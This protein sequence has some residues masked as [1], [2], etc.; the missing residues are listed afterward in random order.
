MKNSTQISRLKAVRT[1][2]ETNFKHKI[3]QAQISDIACYSYRN[4]NRIFKAVYTESIGNCIKRLQIEASAKEILYTEKSITDIAYEAG[5]SDLQAFNKSFK[6]IYGSSPLQF[7]KKKNAEVQLWQQTN[8]VNMK[9]HT[10]HINYRVETL[11]DLKVLYLPYHGPYDIQAIDD[12]WL[13]LLEYAEKHQLLDDK[14]LFLGEVIDDEDIAQPD[15]CRYNCTLTLAGNVEFQPAGF[16]YIKVLERQKYAIFSH[17]GSYESMEDTYDLIYGQWLIREAFEPI[18]KPVLELYV[19]GGFG[20]VK[21]EL[22]TEICIP[23]K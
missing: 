6:T 2:V 8:E 1:F 21:D 14:T 16:Q 22:L 19:S 11:P 13:L 12:C 5:Y 18:D 4:I 20:A 3:S 9:E 10:G 17:R 15:K 23:V 7:R